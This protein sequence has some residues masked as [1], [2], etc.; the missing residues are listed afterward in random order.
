[1]GKDGD[2]DTIL[3]T[4][5]KNQW[6]EHTSDDIRRFS[7]DAPSKEEH[8]DIAFLATRVLFSRQYTR[9]PSSFESSERLYFGIPSSE[10]SF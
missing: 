9:D 10:W 3:P 1:M 4:Q 5:S 8:L 2:A 6:S 7:V